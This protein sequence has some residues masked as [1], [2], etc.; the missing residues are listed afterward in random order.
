MGRQPTCNSGGLHGLWYSRLSLPESEAETQQ[1]RGKRRL[2]VTGRDYGTTKV[3]EAC[4]KD[5]L[6]GGL[7]A[8]GLWSSNESAQVH[9]PVLL[10]AMAYI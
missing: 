2:G 1:Q 8:S 9:L 7:P 10:A 5:N 6:S 3:E 4:S